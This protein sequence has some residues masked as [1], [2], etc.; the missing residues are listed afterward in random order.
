MGLDV[1]GPGSFVR[2][3][4]FSVD[5]QVADS[6]LSPLTPYGVAKAYA[7]FITRSYRRRYGL[8]A[9][10][11]I[12]YNHESPRRPLEFLPSKVANA[13]ASIG[14]GLSAGIWLGD[15]DALRSRP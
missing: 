15:L 4:M 3:A 8:H 1:P 11:G 9:C 2:Q 6:P 7:H 12:L 5:D 13:A 14:L 10:A